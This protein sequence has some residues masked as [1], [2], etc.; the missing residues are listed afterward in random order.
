MILT[1]YAPNEF[2]FLIDKLNDYGSFVN[3]TKPLEGVKTLNLGVD[4]LL[5]NSSKTFDLH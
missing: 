5:T 4:S 2:T 1:F 3:D